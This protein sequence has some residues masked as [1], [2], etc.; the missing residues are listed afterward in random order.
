MR[1][2]LFLTSLPVTLLAGCDSGVGVPVVPVV[3]VRRPVRVEQRGDSITHQSGDYLWQALPA[4]SFVVNYGLDGQQASDAV[5]G[6]YGTL[7]TTL[8]KDT[9]YTFS[10]G[11]N[12]C[13]Q[14]SGPEVFKSNLQ[15]IITQMRG[16]RTIL[17]APW[18]LT[19]QSSACSDHI[20]EYRQVIVDLVR[21][22]QGIP[23]YNIG[24]PVLDTN[25]D[26]IGEGIHL[27]AD[28]SKLRMKLM[29]DAIYKLK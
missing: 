18:S 10:W 29:A 14:G 8:D 15:H 23:G 20:Q 1:R 9:F 24:M 27:G 25:Q 6:I 26:N 13:L 2:R 19:N 16:Y 11:A 22:Y 5:A 3:V 7:P 28:H 21:T 4:G 12:E 17:E